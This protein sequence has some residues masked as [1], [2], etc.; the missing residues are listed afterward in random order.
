MIGQGGQSVGASAG[1]APEAV[2][3]ICEN[4]KMPIDREPYRKG[5]RTFC[6]DGCAYGGPCVC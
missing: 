5:E 6:C 4:C 3:T 1:R 2:E